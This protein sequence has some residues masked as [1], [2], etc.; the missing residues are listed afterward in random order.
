VEIRGITL[1]AA[2]Q[3][4]EQVSDQFYNGNV[5]AHEGTDLAGV[6]RLADGSKGP[7]CKLVLRP[8]GRG[9]EG[10]LHRRGRRVNACDWEVHRDV[11]R[12]LFGVNPNAIV[13][14]GMS[15]Y[16]GREDFE[17]NH[18]ATYDAFYRY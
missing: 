1:A 15:T 7:K 4:V 3:V 13:V 17:A 10:R 2:E 11:M 14:T 5:A 9:D 16:R 6:S 18:G 8:A 12:A